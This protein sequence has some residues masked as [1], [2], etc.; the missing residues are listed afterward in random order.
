[1]IS[2]IK[3][4]DGRVEPFDKAKIFVAVMKAMNDVDECDEEVAERVASKIA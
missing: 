2:E 3:K 1:M 4:R